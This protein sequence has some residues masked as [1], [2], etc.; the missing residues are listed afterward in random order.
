MDMKLYVKKCKVCGKTIQ[1]LYEHQANSNLK[2]HM[3]THE[4]NEKKEGNKNGRKK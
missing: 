2:S 1:S 3:I 4:K